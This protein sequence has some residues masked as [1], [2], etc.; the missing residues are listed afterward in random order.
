MTNTIYEYQSGQ[1][2]RLEIFYND[3]YNK[4]KTRRLMKTLIQQS[5]RWWSYGMVAIVAHAVAGHGLWTYCSSLMERYTPTLVI[6]HNT[7]MTTTQALVM[8]LT[9]WSAGWTMAWYAWLS[10]RYVTQVKQRTTRCIDEIERVFDQ[11][12]SNV[13]VMIDNDKKISSIGK[14]RILGVAI[15]R[16][17]EINNHLEEGQIQVNALGSR[18][19]L[20]LVQ[21]A[22]QFARQQDIKVITQAQRKNRLDGFI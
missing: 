5:Q 7:R 17:K 16:C 2:K 1:R 21:N 3:F 15:L 4:D 10:H 13:W 8:E 9:L 12:K 20:A 11:P 18:I 6:N 19:E 22:I 14:G